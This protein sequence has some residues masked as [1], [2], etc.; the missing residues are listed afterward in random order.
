[1]KPKASNPHRELRVSAEPGEILA[2]FTVDLT[3]RAVEGQ[4]SALLPTALKVEALVEDAIRENSLQNGGGAYTLEASA[5][6][7]RTDK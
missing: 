6:A 4:A 2:T 7:R 3:L 5:R 1:M